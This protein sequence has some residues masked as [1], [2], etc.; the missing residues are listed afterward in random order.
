MPSLAKRDLETHVAHH[1]RDDRAALQPSLPAQLLG[2]HQEDRVAVDDRAGMIDEDGAIAVAVEGHAQLTAAAHDMRSQRLRVGRSAE[3]IDVA[4]VR[5]VADDDGADPERL[6]QPGRD[7]RRGAVG[8]VDPQHQTA[9]AA[10]FRKHPAQ[11]VEIGLD[12]VGAGNRRRL[13]VHHRPRRVGDDRFDFPLHPFGEFL[14]PAG[15]HLDAVVLERIVRRRDHHASVIAR[16]SGEIGDSRSRYDARAR[17]AGTL[18][19]GAV[20]Q[21]GFNPVAGF[22]GVA[23]DQQ[24]RCRRRAVRQRPD[25]RRAEPP[26]RRRVERIAAGDAAHAVGSKEAGDRVSFCQM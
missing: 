24:T 1:G 12:Q 21:R 17:H 16:G 25:Q 2:A 18:P 3:Q 22:A 14:A 11:M 8:A 23:P 15:E 4:A 5:F 10:G 9:Q 13:A 7:R 20:R 6:E 26:C 19:R